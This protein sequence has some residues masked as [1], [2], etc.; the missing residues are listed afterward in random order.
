MLEGNDRRGKVHSDECRDQYNYCAD[1]GEDF[2][3]ANTDLEGL[4]DQIFHLADYMLQL[5]HDLL[6]RVDKDKEGYLVI[7]SDV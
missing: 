5:V 3:N 6:L 4:S 1:D 2:V 7:K